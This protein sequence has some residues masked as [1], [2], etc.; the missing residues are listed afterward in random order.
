MAGSAP[1]TTAM[2]WTEHS[3]CQ[4]LRERFRHSGNGGSGK[5]AFLRQVRSAS[6]F[7]GWPPIRTAD[8]VTLS[9]WP[10]HGFLLEAYEV[11]VSRSDWLRELADLEKSETWRRIADKWWIVAP[12]S[13]VKPDELP[14]GWGLI[15]LLDDARTRVKVQAAHEPAEQRQIPRTLLA[16]I[17]RSCP[18]VVPT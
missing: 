18:E 2:K 12:V 4:A 7:S 17:L 3:A 8:A 15:E 9:L 14:D 1:S 10:S 13:M 6:G 5:Y 11:K 16:A